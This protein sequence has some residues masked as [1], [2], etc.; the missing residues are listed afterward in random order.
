MP[1]I[2]EIDALGLRC[3]MPVIKLQKA[4]RK[5]L[6]G[7]QLSIF[8]TDSGASKDIKSWCKVNRHIFLNSEETGQQY[9]NETDI[10][11]IT[12]QIKTD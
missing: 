7:A 5:S 4:V 3:P 12:I 11:R 2:T 6:P 8:C 9:K 1:Q 10:I